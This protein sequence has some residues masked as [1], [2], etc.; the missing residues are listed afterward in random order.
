MSEPRLT[1]L[2]AFR[3]RDTARVRRCL[4]SLKNQRAPAFRVIFVDYGSRTQNAHEVQAVLRQ[5]PFCEY[6][7]SDTRGYPWNKPR[8]LNIGIHRVQ[9]EYLLA[10]DIDM[11]FPEDFIATVLD[12]VDENRL[13]HCYPYY[14]PQHFDYARYTEAN[15]NDLKLGG[16]SQTGGCQ[17]VKTDILKQIRGFDENYCYWG[18]ED[19]DLSSRLEHMGLEIFWLNDHTDAYLLHQWHPTADYETPGYMPEGWWI[20]IEMYYYQNLGIVM[21]NREDWGAL[22]TAD[23]REVFRF[24]AVDEM[25]LIDSPALTHLELR[26]DSPYS[27]DK[28]QRVFMALPSGRAVAVHQAAYPRVGK[29]VARFFRFSNRV[30]RRLGIP[31]GI[32][33]RKNSLHSYLAALLQDRQELVADYFLNIPAHSGTTII[34]KR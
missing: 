4:D 29:S 3:D 32:D 17:C 5:Y 31:F 34:V 28:F 20:R 19:S 18:Q 14:L 25:R 10:S 1:I 7:Y 9:T 21:R 22:H 27:I 12:H 24:L 33:Y 6:I 16:K 11:I 23:Q 26:P 8:A 2:F 30:L 15:L 13:I